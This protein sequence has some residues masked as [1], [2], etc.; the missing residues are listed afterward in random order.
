MGVISLVTNKVISNKIYTQLSL[1][2]DLIDKVK[3]F[4]NKPLM[5]IEGMNMSE[6]RQYN[7]KDL[8]E[9]GVIL[10]IDPIGR[11]DDSETYTHKLVIKVDLVLFDEILQDSTTLIEDVGHKVYTGFFDVEDIV[12]QIIKDLNEIDFEEAD[13]RGIDY[14]MPPIEDVSN[15]TVYTSYISLNLNIER[16]WNG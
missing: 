9:Y 14:E 1:S 7:N 15:N 10:T 5:I 13:V 8:L 16:C 12:L 11:E 6:F 3:S 4:T 2:N